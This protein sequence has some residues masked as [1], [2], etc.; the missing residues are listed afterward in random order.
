[1]PTYNN[2]KYLSLPQQVQKNKDEIE[3]I[4][5]K[6]DILEEQFDEFTNSI[7]DGQIVNE[8]INARDGEVSLGANITEIKSQLAQIPPLP[9]QIR[10]IK[11]FDIMPTTAQLLDG[12]VGLVIKPE[13]TNMYL[14]DEPVLSDFTPTIISGVTGEYWS[15]TMP[16]PKIIDGTSPRFG[17][18]IDLEVKSITAYNDLM[19]GLLDTANNRIIRCGF[20]VNATTLTARAYIHNVTLDVNGNIT[21]LGNSLLSIVSVGIPFGDV[22]INKPLNLKLYFDGISQSKISL[23]ESSGRILAEPINNSFSAFSNSY[24]KFFALVI[25]TPGDGGTPTALIEYQ[26]GRLYLKS[27]AVV[28][29]QMEVY[30]DQVNLY[31]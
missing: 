11:I 26:S 24:N 13:E 5:P 20:L 9:P 18:D 30:I 31:V 14:A 15:K 2:P 7:I 1:M 25:T 12:E 22:P 6:V 8:V 28:P 16:L 23:L 10:T 3:I 17:F 27:P 4:K 21:N 19:F 29:N